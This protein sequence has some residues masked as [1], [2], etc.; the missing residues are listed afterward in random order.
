MA[1]SVSWQVQDMMLSREPLRAARL[2]AFTLF[3]LGLMG[4]QPFFFRV[5]GLDILGPK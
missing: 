1:N 4:Q 2:V 5:T 3:M